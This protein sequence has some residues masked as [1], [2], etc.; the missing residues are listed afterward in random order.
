MNGVSY[1]ERLNG[2]IPKL[3]ANEAKQLHLGMF[4]TFSTT[5]VTFMIEKKKKIPTEKSKIAP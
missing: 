1:S 3:N 2:K 4:T 5:C